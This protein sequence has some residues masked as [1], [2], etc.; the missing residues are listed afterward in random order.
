MYYE[1]LKTKGL[2]R[3]LLA[4]G[5]TETIDKKRPELANRKGVS[6]HHDN[7]KSSL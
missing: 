3:I 5:P 1:F 6:F 2:I 7:A 4:I